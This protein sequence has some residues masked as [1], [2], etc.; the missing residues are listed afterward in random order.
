ML[1]VRQAQKLRFEQISRNALASGF[2]RPNRVNALRLILKCKFDGPHRM[3]LM[4]ESEASPRISRIH[5]AEKK[6]NRF[7]N[8]LLKKSSLLLQ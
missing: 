5:Q 7:C 2:H 1:L 3:R 6:Y 8:L 4:E